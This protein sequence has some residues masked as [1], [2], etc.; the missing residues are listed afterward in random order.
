M[1][2]PITLT[3]VGKWVASIL[4]GVAFASVAFLCIT[5]VR[6][7]LRERRM[8][9]IHGVAAMLKTR[10]AEGDYIVA[11]GFFEDGELTEHQAWRAK[12]VDAELRALPEGRIVTQGRI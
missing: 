1:I 5:K 3:L 8:Q 4:V 10:T 9:H 11:A 7:Y 6:D 12:D 2:D